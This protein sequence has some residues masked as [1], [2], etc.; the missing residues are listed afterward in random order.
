MIP[1]SKETYTQIKILLKKPIITR[2][3]IFIRISVI[4]IR[5]LHNLHELE[6]CHLFSDQKLRLIV[7]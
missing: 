6:F 4:L 5:S 2:R 7:Q 3:L 1:R